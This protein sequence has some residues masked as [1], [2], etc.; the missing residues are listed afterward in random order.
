MS[1]PKEHIFA[2]LAVAK[3]EFR[4]I[5]YYPMYWFC[6]VLLPL[7]VI[8]FFTDIMHEGLPTDVPMGVVDL[9]NSTTS[10]K[11]M[12]RLESFP[13]ARIVANYPTFSAAREDMQ[14][15]KIY[16]IMYIPEGMAEDMIAGHKPTISFY[17]NNSVL[18][19]G[20]LLYKELRA[21]STM[22]SL[23]MVQTKMQALGVPQREIMGTLQPVIIE[24]HPID[25]P[26]LN[27]NVYLSNIIIPACIAI[28]IFLMTAYT[29]GVEI[30]F[31]TAREWMRKA[32]G[33][34]SVAMLGKILP[35]TFFFAL[36][37]WFYQYW[38]F[39]HLG[40][41]H[42]SSFAFIMCVGLIFVLACQGL[43]IFI[44]GIM[45]S[46]R[47]SMSICALWSVLSFSI[48]G[49][50]FP[51]DAMDPPIQAMAWMFPLRSYFMIYQMNIFH[52]FPVA[53]SWIYFIALMVFI[54]LPLLVLR[55]LKTVLNTYEYIP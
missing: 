20:S 34:V 22:A 8:F 24:A 39:V 13:T 42:N 32:K 12:R 11:L 50:S 18:L 41:P 17:Y 36:V 51:V 21:I 27:Y 30:K 5:G 49:F 10:R 38:L 43:G 45:P 2:F 16:A 29:I 47:M 31:G 19:A 14:E 23:A 55:H 28:F 9:D 7:F 25:N 52:G 44:F 26:Y 1:S 15:K 46:M 54:M 40:F 6:M 35:Q 33:H 53:D 37:V 48:S 3:R 4:H